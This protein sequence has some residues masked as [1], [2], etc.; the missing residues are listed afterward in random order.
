MTIII[1]MNVVDNLNSV[2]VINK[3]CVWS[4]TMRL[5]TFCGLHRDTEQYLL[6]ISNVDLSKKELEKTTCEY[7]VCKYFTDRTRDRRLEVSPTQDTA[8]IWPR[9]RWA[10][11]SAFISAIS[12]I[13]HRHILF[14]YRTKTCRTKF[15]HS[16]IGR[17]NIDIIFRSAIRLN[18]HRIF[19]YLKL[20][21]SS[22][23][24]RVRLYD[25]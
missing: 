1:S 5:S 20:I 16:H 3:P 18:Q 6:L 7:S 4:S 10:S 19:R 14:R 24:T 2:Q 17:V 23:M 11:T 15:F 21:N 9:H 13:R 25:I 8:Q 12:D 22:Q